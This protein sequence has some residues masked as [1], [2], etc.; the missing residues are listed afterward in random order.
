M[1]GRTAPRIAAMDTFRWSV[2]D[3]VTR[4]GTQQ[5]KQVRKWSCSSLEMDSNVF[6]LVYF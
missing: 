1:G 3:V 6:S 4:T 2:V 5:L